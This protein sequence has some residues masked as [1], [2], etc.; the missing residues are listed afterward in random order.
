MISSIPLVTVVIPVYNC[1]RYIG[2]AIQSVLDQDYP[3]I[4][5]IVVDDGSDDDTVA[6]AKYFG[7][8]INLLCQPN[9]GPASAR[10]LGV[11]ASRGD[12]LAFLDGDDIWLPGKL[13]DQMRYLAEHPEI[14]VV[15][16]RWERWH[17]AAN[18]AFPPP[19]SVVH[20]DAARR[21]GLD[22]EIS[23]WIYPQMLLDSEVCIITALITRR[24][25]EELEGF[26]ES[27]QTGE[28]YDF[29]L[30]ASRRVQIHKL[31]RTVALYRQHPQGTT[32]VV[33]PVSNAYLV[34]MRALERYGEIGPD[35]RSVDRIRL[36]QRLAQLC[37]EHGYQHFWHGDPSI[38]AKAFAQ[39][40]D[41]GGFQ[42]KTA[43]YAIASQLSRGWSFVFGK[44]NPHSMV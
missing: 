2:E 37:F 44:Q 39:S 21:E 40:L 34:L 4:E 23:G 15:F 26:N 25:F 14:G 41:H 5:V 11:R 13:S 1:G 20:A 9:R 31:A 43:A 35:G 17:P 19:D 8:R 7:N 6:Q 38:A 29:W 30:R 18:G 24:L 33:R 28:D 3:R 12:Y 42:W 32:H 22:T 10:N 16:S 36:R 27:L